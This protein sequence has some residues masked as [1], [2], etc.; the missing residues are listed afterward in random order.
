MALLHGTLLFTILSI[1][2]SRS[3]LTD[4][5]IFGQPE[6]IH[7]SYGRDPTLMIVTWVTLNQ[8][9][10]S[11]VEYGQDDMFDLR[12]TGNVSIFQDSGSEKRREYIHR[13]VLNNLKPGQRY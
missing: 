11:V 3:I 5:P 8:I 2:S 9:N 6:Q 12:A 10:E 13:V 1:V 7:I 4:D